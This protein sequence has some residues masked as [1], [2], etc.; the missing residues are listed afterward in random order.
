MNT[1]T[2]LVSPLMPMLLSRGDAIYV[3]HGRLVVTPASGLP[4]PQ[5]WIDENGI[6]LVTEMLQQ[7]GQDAFV[8]LAYTTGKYG[9]NLAGGVTLQFRHLLTGIKTYAIFNADLTRS[10]STKN[11]K[12]GDSLPDRQF[13]LAKGAAFFKFWD[14]AGVK[15]P[16]SNT[17]FYKRMGNLKPLYFT[18]DSHLTKQDRLINDSIKPL[19]VTLS[20]VRESHNL[21]DNLAITQRQLSDNSAITVSDKET[22]KCPKT[23][24]LQDDSATCTYRYGNKVIR[25]KVIRENVYPINTKDKGNDNGK[26][27]DRENSPQIANRPED[28][29]VDEW[30]TEYDEAYFAEHGRYL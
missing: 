8:Y 10:R 25:K 28:Q 16:L 14:K 4:V 11:G 6:N 30:L 24:G 29:T 17:E 3:D 19:Q 13:H 2:K 5:K 1:Q 23:L 26:Y 18:A 12:V 20:Q 7:T 21:S 27:N 15:R 22:P 9:K